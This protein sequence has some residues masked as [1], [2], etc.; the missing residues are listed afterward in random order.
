MFDKLKNVIKGQAGNSVKI[1]SPIEGEAVP[2]SEVNDAAFSGEMLG[3][4]VAIKPSKGRVVAPAD[5]EISMMFNTGHAVA[6]KLDGDVEVLIHVGLDTVNLK[7]ECFKIYASNDDKVRK[8]DLLIEFDMD[9]VLKKGYD[10]ITPV[11]VT[12]HDEFKSLEP[13]IMGHVSEGDELIKITL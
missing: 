11:I 7:G 1:F 10:L 4:G 3:R 12:N 13:H 2:L 5:G 8:G 6:L 9:G